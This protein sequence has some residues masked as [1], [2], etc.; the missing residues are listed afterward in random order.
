MD[1]NKLEKNKNTLEQ[2]AVESISTGI[3]ALKGL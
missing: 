2:T 1:I 3:F